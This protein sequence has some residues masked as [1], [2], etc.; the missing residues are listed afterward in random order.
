[1]EEVFGSPFLARAMMHNMPTEEGTR[2]W[3]PLPDSLFGP[4]HVAKLLIQKV[5]EKRSKPEKPYRL[6]AEQLECIALLVSALD[7]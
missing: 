2:E 6:N 4:A 5:Q 3:I 1:M 7:K